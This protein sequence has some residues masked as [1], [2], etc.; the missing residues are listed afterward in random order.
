[1][2]GQQNDER[3][4]GLRA[5]SG[6]APQQRSPGVQLR[7]GRDGLVQLRFQRVPLLL[8]EADVLANAHLEGRGC[9]A[10]LVLHGRD[11]L[12]H[13]RPARTKRLQILGL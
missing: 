1:V 10:Q 7:V 5:D 2:L 4:H 13:L 11:H 3:A 9:H 12:D 6:R 8:K